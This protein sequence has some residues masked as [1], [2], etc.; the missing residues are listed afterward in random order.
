MIYCELDKLIIVFFGKFCLQQSMLNDHML[1]DHMLN[2]H[3][4]NDH[5]LNDHMYG[6]LSSLGHV[7]SM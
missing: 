6:L 3:M 7:L 1:N 5:M 4:L 2:D